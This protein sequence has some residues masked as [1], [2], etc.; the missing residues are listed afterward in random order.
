[1]T[2]ETSLSDQEIV[3]KYIALPILPLFHMVYI[4]NIVPFV[5]RTITY[6]LFHEKDPEE[7]AY[8]K[9]NELLF[10]DKEQC[11]P[12]VICDG[13]G[14]TYLTSPEFWVT[15]SHIYEKNTLR[16]M[17]G[18]ATIYPV[19]LLIDETLFNKCNWMST[20]YQLLPHD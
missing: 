15:L 1:M 3:K 12:I 17:N 10:H 8:T 9:H 11:V 16:Q 6:R 4:T 20:L 18:K 13:F 14:K 2:E 19:N 5:H 7:F